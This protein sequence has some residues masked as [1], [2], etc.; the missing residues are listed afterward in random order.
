[1]RSR[2]VQTLTPPQLRDALRSRCNPFSSAHCSARRRISVFVSD[3]TCPVLLQRCVCTAAPLLTLALSQ[4]LDPF[5]GL[6]DIDIATAI[7]NSTGT[8]IPLFVPEG[9]FDLL[10]KRQIKKLESLVREG[11][12]F[13]PASFV[14]EIIALSLS[15]S[16]LGVCASS[17]LAQGLQCVD[18][19]YEEMQRVSFECEG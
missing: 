3:C 5:D 10:V 9:S 19:V 15:P 13:V 4:D 6:S 7:R 11:T 12:R 8:R 1:M 18:L 2:V 16:G 17:N 14:G